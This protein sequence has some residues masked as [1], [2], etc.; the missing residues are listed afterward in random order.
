M[1]DQFPGHEGDVIGRAMV[2]GGRKAGAVDKDR[3][4]HAQ[5]LG[6]PVHPLYEGGLAAGQVL[7]HSHRRIVTRNH[8]DALDELAGGELLPFLQIDLGAA[9]P[10]SGGGDGDQILFGQPSAV[11][12]LHDEQQGHHLGHAGGL[13]LLV[14]L[15]FIEQRA[16]L[17]LHQYRRSGGEVQV[18][19]LRCALL[20]CRR[21]GARKQ[22]GCQ[23][24]GN[25]PLLHAK[26]LPIRM[27]WFCVSTGCGG[28][29]A[30]MQKGRTVIFAP[31][32]ITRSNREDCK[33]RREAEFYVT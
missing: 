8:R 26:Y 30:S 5:L 4:L 16:C 27:L 18:R 21:R 24:Q 25:D 3:V 2:P 17:L 14:G 23:Q 33:T 29:T 32:T 19:M 7:R 28:W 15:L 9:H 6:P 22:G 13:Q 20:S 10:R 11:Q 1:Q 12:V 31:P